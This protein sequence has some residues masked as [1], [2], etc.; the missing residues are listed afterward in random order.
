MLSHVSTIILHHFYAF[1]RTNLLTRCLVP[2]FCF[3][4]FCISENLLL[5][6][7]SELDEN[8]RE[9]FTRRKAPGHQR[10][11]WGPPTGQGRPPAAAQGHQRVGPPSS[12]PSD[13]YKIPLNLKTSERPLFSKEVTRRAV[14][15]NPSSGVILK[16]IPTLCRRG[17]RSRRALHRHAFL[18]DDL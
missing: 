4:C 1:C 18:R 2:V 8:L 9:I 6:I 7:F 17:Y 13:A 16:E 14:I 5:E 12:A 15:S 11:A 3:F 10:G